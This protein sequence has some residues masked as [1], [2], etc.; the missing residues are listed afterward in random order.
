MLQEREGRKD[1]EPRSEDGQ[2]EEV[3]VQ[4]L[5]EVEHGNPVSTH[6]HTQTH[7]QK[8][9]HTSDPQYCF[10]HSNVEYRPL[11]LLLLFVQDKTVEIAIRL[12]PEQLAQVAPVLEEI[13]HDIVEERQKGKVFKK[14]DSI[15]SIKKKK[16]YSTT[17]PCIF[18]YYTH[19]QVIVIG[20]KPYAVL[21]LSLSPQPNSQGEDTRG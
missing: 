9:T 4:Q 7:T 16:T 8:H 11:T 6:T 3:T 15:E 21:S 2:F 17:W 13:I 19:L 5:P 18:F 1:M 20:S 12:S 14:M 10:H